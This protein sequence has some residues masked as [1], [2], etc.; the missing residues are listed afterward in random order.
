MKVK[1]NIIF[2]KNKKIGS[3]II[4]NC[5]K[6]LVPDIANTPSHV[7]LLLKD[8]W[9]YESTME[10]GVRVIKYIDWLNINEE[11]FKSEEIEGFD[12]NC[13]KPKINKLKESKYDYLGVIYYSLYALIKLIFKKPM[14]KLNKWQSNSK[15]FCCELVG[16]IINE[17]YQMMCP[18]EIMKNLTI[19]L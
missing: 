2:S 3:K 5:T 1:A 13:I 11:V 8:R 10:T 14:P 16:E 4:S 9:I 19:K 15:Y 17:D 18:V 12:Y 6:F 7:V